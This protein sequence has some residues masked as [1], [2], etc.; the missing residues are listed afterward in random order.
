MSAWQVTRSSNSSL[1]AK[2]TLA[3][4]L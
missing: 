4:H 2:V 1:S 3:N